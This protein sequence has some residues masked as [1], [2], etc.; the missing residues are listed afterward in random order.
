MELSHYIKTAITRQLVSECMCCLSSSP[1]ICS[2][3][4]VWKGGWGKTLEAGQLCC[5]FRSTVLAPSLAMYDVQY[6]MYN[7]QYAVCNVWGQLCWPPTN[8]SCLAM[9]RATARP[10]S[11]WPFLLQPANRPNPSLLVLTSLKDDYEEDVQVQD[12]SSS[13]PYFLS[14]LGSSWP[15]SC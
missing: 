2:W 1:N 15:P 4:E 13:F 5:C 12:P 11:C 14:A 3:S 6:A 7:V 8:S 9:A 10:P